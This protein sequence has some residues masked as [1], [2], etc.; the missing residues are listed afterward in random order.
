MNSLSIGELGSLGSQS[1]IFSIA[2]D[3]KGVVCGFLLTLDETATYSSP[4]Y[5][6]FLRRHPRFLYVDRIVV[7][8]EF[9]GMGIGRSLYQNVIDELATQYPV[10]ACEVNLSPPNPG[11]MAFHEKMGFRGVAEQETEGGSKRVLLMEK[12]L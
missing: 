2:L 11:S 9:H 3:D 4:N 1:K 10:L 6:Y 12:Q 7:G 8:D 5:Q